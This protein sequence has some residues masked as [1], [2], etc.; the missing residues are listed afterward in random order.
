M[1]SREALDANTSSI[2]YRKGYIYSTMALIHTSE[3]SFVMYGIYGHCSIP[4]IDHS[5]VTSILVSVCDNTSDFTDIILCNMDA[6]RRYWGLGN[7][8]DLES[9]TTRVRKFER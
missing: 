6:L 3:A 1:S 8:T 5:T 4:F 9:P 2:Q 7:D